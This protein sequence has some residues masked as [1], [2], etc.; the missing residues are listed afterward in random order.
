M[1][2]VSDT[3]TINK[4]ITILMFF[5]VFKFS[6]VKYFKKCA[7]FRLSLLKVFKEMRLF[8]LYFK[9]VHS[10]SYN[11]TKFNKSTPW[12]IHPLYQNLPSSCINN[13]ETPYKS[14]VN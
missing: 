10:R 7:F 1:L 5:V 4:K 12:A 2:T 3:Q 11:E 6:F 9:L 8:L 14:V 13:C